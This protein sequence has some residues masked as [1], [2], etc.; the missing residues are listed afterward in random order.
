MIKKTIVL[1]SGVSADFHVI[2]HF[3]FSDDGGCVAEIASFASLDDACRQSGVLW[4]S[5]VRCDG[6]S[7][8]TD[9]LAQIYGVMAQ[10][11]RFA[12]FDAL[13]PD[14]AN[15]LA[16]PRTPLPAKPAAP[17]P[18]HVW[19]KDQWAWVETP[20]AV[21]NARA[22]ARERI[23]VARNAAEREPFA[24]FGKTFDADD[25]AIQRILGAAQ[26]AVVAKQLGQ[27]LSIEWTCADNTTLA[28]DADMLV[29][30][31]VILAQAADTLHQRARSLKAQIDAATSLAEI[32]AVTW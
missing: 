8:D 15:G 21:T 13:S 7:P 5:C 20:E 9:T 6:I 22:A 25:K 32:E 30:I 26:A 2:R 10:D 1:P 3:V 29:E 19:D 14:A 23:N 31:P 28:M 11:E 17:S 16:N 27:P 4:I 24:A 12:G 18:W